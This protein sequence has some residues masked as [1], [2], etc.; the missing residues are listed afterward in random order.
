MPIYFYEIATAADGFGFNNDKRI[1]GIMTKWI[2]L[3]D[4]GNAL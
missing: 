4:P 1:R 3:R 2:P